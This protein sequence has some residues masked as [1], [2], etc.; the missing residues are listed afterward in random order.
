MTTEIDLCS[1][2]T[3]LPI[4][5]MQDSEEGCSR[6]EKDQRMTVRRKM[7]TMCVMALMLIGAAGSVFGQEEAASVEEPVSAMFVV[8]NVWM[9]AGY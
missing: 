9:M 7:L 3:E 1:G 2:V 6:N 4:A 5:V 8:N